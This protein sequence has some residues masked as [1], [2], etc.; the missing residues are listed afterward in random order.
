MPDSKYLNETGIFQEQA[1][2][3]AE[4]GG[5]ALINEVNCGFRL[6][7]AAWKP[8][9]MNSDRKFTTGEVLRSASIAADLWK[10]ACSPSLWSEE[11]QSFSNDEIGTLNI[12]LQRYFQTTYS[13]RLLSTTFYFILFAASDK[14]G[15]GGRKEVFD[16][17]CNL[18][19]SWNHEFLQGKNQESSYLNRTIL[20]KGQRK[21]PRVAYDLIEPILSKCAAQ[22]NDDAIE[23]E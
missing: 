7:L 17:D 19:H 10:R 8:N 13:C 20:W 3:M 18:Q 6:C 4:D 1:A 15:S 9:F 11:Q 16:G 23:L 22:V 2:F 12:K 14:R 21:G 5:D